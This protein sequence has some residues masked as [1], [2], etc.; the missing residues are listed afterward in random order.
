[1]NSSSDEYHSE[2]SLSDVDPFSFKPKSFNQNKNKT[3][4]MKR[5]SG[6][7]RTKNVKGKSI[8]GWT[9][10]SVDLDQSSS[11][12]SSS[13][14]DEENDLSSGIKNRSNSVSLNNYGSKLEPVKIMPK[15]DIIELESS[16]DSDDDID[17]DSNNRHQSSSTANEALKQA[18]A[19]RELLCQVQYDNELNTSVNCFDDLETSIEI[20]ESDNED[21][22][23]DPAILLM[24]RINGNEKVRKR[25][26]CVLSLLFL[27]FFACNILFVRS[28]GRDCKWFQW[29]YI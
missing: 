10:N 17:F 15:Q 21:E 18:R 19:A 25:S 11:S 5:P 27:Y 2:D 20:N 26:W 23:E 4:S 12:S 6:R 13:S 28:Y 9:K 14:D 22:E 7:K 24:T 29:G 1:M 8:S 3:Q 16:S